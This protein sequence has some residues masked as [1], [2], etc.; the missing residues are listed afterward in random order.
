MAAS[1][2]A[3]VLVLARVNIGQADGPTLDEE[4]ENGHYF[5]QAAP[6]ES[7]AERLGF[8]VTDREGARFWSEFRR[9]G[10]T[11][12][13]GYPI[14]RRFTLEG[15]T[16]QAF[17]RG[18][19]RWH[20]DVGEGHL[21]N[22]MDAS[23]ILAMDSPALASHFLPAHAARATAN[24]RAGWLTQD[25][26][27]LAKY[28]SIDR[29]AE[30]LGSPT[31]PPADFGPVVALRFQRGVIHRWK[32]RHVWT[33]DHGAS[34]A[35]VGDLARERGLIPAAALQPEPPPSEAERA[36]VRAARGLEIA[37]VATWYGHDF[38]G[39]LMANGRPFD[40][41]NPSTAASNIFPLGSLLR[42]TRVVTGASIVVRVTDRGAFRHPNLVDLSYAAFASFADPNDGVIRVRVE[43]IG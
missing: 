37:G 26:G 35:N 23:A 11:T 42:V 1:C 41:W 15:F 40:M 28:Q 32:S 6:R 18:I 29:A 9:L 36:R 16:A 8:T 13:L 2:L 43:R 10:G 38:H 31:A 5:T 4:I 14:S 19:L 7:S 39:A 25:G 33:D 27:I 3:A 24:D 21:Y 22:V 12:T 34:L 17:Q 30:V 20:P